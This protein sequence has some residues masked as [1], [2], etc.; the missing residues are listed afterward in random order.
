VQ[1]NTCIIHKDDPC[2][3]T[4]CSK[5]TA[6]GQNPQTTTIHRALWPIPLPP[7]ACSQSILCSIS[8]PQR[9]SCT[10]SST[11]RPMG[12]P[13]GTSSTSL[14]CKRLEKQ[15]LSRHTWHLL[16]YRYSRLPRL[17]I[18]P[19]LPIDSS[20]SQTCRQRP[21]ASSRSHTIPR[22][23]YSV[24]CGSTVTVRTVCKVK[25]TLPTQT[26]AGHAQRVAELSAMHGFTHPRNA[27][28]YK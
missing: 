23:M 10:V 14:W 11:N 25:G 16:R 19:V 15:T 24:Q 18:F 22:A 4:V 9:I 21:A 27:H 13:I 6:L 28:V 8:E 1:A 12:E 7:M 5:G 17:C 20:Y 26:K 3:W 2:A